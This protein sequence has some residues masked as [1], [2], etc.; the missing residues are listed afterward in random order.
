MFTKYNFGLFSA[1]KKFGTLS[2]QRE[3]YSAVFAS[4]YYYNTKCSDITTIP[5]FGV[6]ATNVI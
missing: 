5:Y 1:L 6:Q 4:V 3:K 2:T